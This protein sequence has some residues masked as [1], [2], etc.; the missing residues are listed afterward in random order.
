[1]IEGTKSGLGI[2]I[3]GGRNVTSESEDDFGIFVKEVI[4]GSLAASD[5]KTIDNILSMV[6]Y[7]RFLLN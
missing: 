5:G 7:G 6:K 2:R 3:V 4:T 1:M